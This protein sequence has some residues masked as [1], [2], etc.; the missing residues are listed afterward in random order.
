[1]AEKTIDDIDGEDK[2]VLL[3]VDFNIPLDI[4]SGA[5]SSDSPIRPQAAQATRT[6]ASL[7]SALDAT[8]VVGGSSAEVGQKMGL[9]DKM[10]YGSAGGGA[11][12]RFLEGVTLSG[13]GVLLDTE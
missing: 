11:T 10:T 5:I 2:R 8:T 9:T 4:S 13:A 7:L 6:I 3:K 1:M 12:L